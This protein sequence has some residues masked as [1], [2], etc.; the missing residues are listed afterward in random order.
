MAE[1]AAAP[2]VAAAAACERCGT[3]V[4]PTLLSCPGC[5]KLVH[6]VELQ[7]LA[8]DAER[9]TADG[10]LTRALELW[11][12]ALQLLPGDSG[13][14]AAIAGRV[15]ELGRAVDGPSAPSASRGGGMGKAAGAGALALLAWKF[16]FVLVFVLTKA[17]LLLL[18]LTK[19][20]T[21]TS[22]LAFLG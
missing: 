20:S 7:R 16:K 17:K 10:D 2:P 1:G 14:H 8:G 5:R 19:L 18:G 3:Q 21:F 15:E 6:A 12:G 11:R 4:A 9:A 22:M 13:Q